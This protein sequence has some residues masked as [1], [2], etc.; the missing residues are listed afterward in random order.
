[1]TD[2]GFSEVLHSIRNIKH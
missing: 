1:L 2:G